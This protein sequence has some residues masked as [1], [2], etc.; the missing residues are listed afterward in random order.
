[1]T[2]TQQIDFTMMY[3]THDALRRD[4]G[5]LLQ[6][7]AAGRAES[8]AVRAGWENFKAQLH[9]HHTVEDDDLWPRLYRAVDGQPE[10]LAMLQE[11]EAEHAVLDPMLESVETA[12]TDGDGDASG[13]GDRVVALAGALEAHL[14]HEETTAL[15]LIQAVLTPKDWKAFGAAMRKAQGLKGASVYVP[16]IVDGASTAD[17]QRFFA[18]LPAPLKA[19]NR[20]AFEPRYRRMGLW[21]V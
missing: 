20:L 5:R 12:L 17:R 11:M 19:V 16:W 6:A 21:G 3:V 4:V 13:L 1:M 18:M 10:Q 2:D 15:P 14:H 7:V 8:P 9:L